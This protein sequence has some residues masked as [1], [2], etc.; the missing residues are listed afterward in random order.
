MKLL[1]H[2]L[3]LLVGAGLGIWWGVNHPEA[4]Q[5]VAANEEQQAAK[6]QA[7]VSREKIVLLQKFLGTTQPDQTSTE[8]KQMLEQEKQNLQDAKAKL[9]N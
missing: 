5:N 8:F 1:S 2:L 3:I 4:A 6:I 7:A 9:V